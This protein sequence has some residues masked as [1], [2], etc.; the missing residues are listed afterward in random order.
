MRRIECSVSGASSARRLSSAYPR[1]AARGV[2]SSWLASAMNCRSRISLSWRASSAPPTLSSIWLSAV[3]TCPTSVRGSTS[4]TRSTSSTSPRSSGSAL[5][6]AAVSATRSS[7]RSSRRTS[8]APATPAP[9]SATPITITSMRTRP[10]TT[11]WASPAGWP[12]DVGRRRRSAWRP[13]GSRRP[14]GPPSSVGRRAAARRARPRRPPAPPS[15]PPPRLLTSARWTAPSRTM[16][17]ER[18]RALGRAEEDCRA[19]ADSRP[20]AATELPGLHEDEP[21]ARVRSTSRS[22]RLNRNWRRA[23]VVVTPIT[24]KATASSRRTVATSRARRVCGRPGVLTATLIPR[25]A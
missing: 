18:A 23:S 21:V 22:S 12:E 19:A 11:S 4:R 15:N 2:R 24:A 20:A 13:P 10:S 6:V 14:T 1:I 16:A 9:T 8:T 3:A 17:P 7:G 25:P 5:T